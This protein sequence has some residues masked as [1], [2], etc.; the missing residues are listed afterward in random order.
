MCFKNS[1]VCLEKTSVVAD[2]E[3]EWGWINSNK[4]RDDRSQYESRRAVDPAGQ[5]SSLTSG[6]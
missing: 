3:E 2:D 4:I 5:Q 6:H 1:K